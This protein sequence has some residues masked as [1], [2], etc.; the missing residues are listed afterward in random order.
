MN[1]D[2]FEKKY[3]KNAKLPN[4]ERIQINSPVKIQEK[5]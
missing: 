3:F 4:I 2:Y 1:R 5:L